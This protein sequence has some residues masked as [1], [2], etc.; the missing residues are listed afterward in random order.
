MIGLWA[1]ATALFLAMIALLWIPGGAVLAA[2]G[3]RGLPAL[4]LA[5]AVT[6]GVVGGGAVVASWLGIAWGIP[7]FLGLCVVA[8]VVAAALARVRPRVARHVANPKQTPAPALLIAAGLII[9]ALI[10]LAVVL[11][12]MRDPSLPVQ[13]RDAI[14][15]MNAVHVLLAT[16][17][18]SSL[19][20]ISAS[21][22]SAGLGYYPAVWHALVAL[23]ATPTSV[24]T[25]TNMVAAVIALVVW[26]IGLVA[27]TTVVS[28]HSRWA[29]P[30]VPILAAGFAVFPPAVMFFHGQWP[31]GLSLAL[32]PGVAASIVLALRRRASVQW[33][34]IALGVVGMLAAHPSG[35][36]VLGVIAVALAADWQVR[37]ALSEL[38]TGD[39]RRA[40]LRS[41]GLA[42]AL[43]GTMAV[44]ATV[45]SRASL[46]EFSR[47]EGSRATGMW[48]AFTLQVLVPYDWVPTEQSIALVVLLLVG[49]VVALRSDAA[50]WAAM[51]WVAFVV[52]TGVATGP[53]GRLRALTA[54]WYKD[55]VRIRAIVVTFA[56]VLCAIALDALV[57]RAAL[58][59]RRPDSL[60][61]EAAMAAVVLLV[62][63]S[64]TGWWHRSLRHDQWVAAGFHP[65][66]MAAPP[67][68]DAKELQFIRSL[69]SLLPPGSVVVGDPL[70]GAAL[71]QVMTRHESYIPV[72]GGSGTGED[73]EYLMEHFAALG[74]DPRVCEILEGAGA[75]G[76]LGYL[77][78][79]TTDGVF[80][81]AVA[82][83]PGFAEVPGSAVELVA[84]SDDASVWRITACD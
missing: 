30:T 52:L 41:A 84:E 31:F 81:G 42:L 72:I 9:G 7:T 1:P 25:A 50:R 5:P 61:V 75:V 53:E 24:T 27:L 17:D 65:Q 26:P 83:G 19:G 56:V 66:F 79:G 73:Q 12:G 34:G 44:A 39:A 22:D 82:A 8:L 29:A 43:L 57:R 6:A 21:A 78:W 49:A 4:A 18:A 13:N 64:S 48:E 33:A 37:L 77:Y 11:P 35:A 69:D 40:A 74:A 2:L 68:A 38:R 47:V 63:G 58:A 23:I 67:L 71:V 76:G 14:F 15:H 28:P 20:G 54:F 70:S 60:Q 32:V 62:V 51:T 16:G 45:A 80:L 10:Q 36:G 46:A 59:A 3:F 55:E